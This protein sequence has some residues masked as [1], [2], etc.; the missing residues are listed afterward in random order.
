MK[1][2]KAFALS[3]VAA[4]LSV[5]SISG[6]AQEDGYLKPAID[7]A[8]KINESAATSQQKVNSYAEQIDS[9]LVEFR[10]IVKETDGYKVYNDQMRQQ[11]SAQEQEMADLNASI[12]KVSV[13]ERQIT[14]LMLRMI[15]GL[16]Q[17]IELDVPFLPEERSKRIADL[18]SMM[19]RADVTS[20][21]KFRRIMEAY[22]VEMN[23]GKGIE[24]YEGS[25]DI[26]GQEQIVDFLRVGR[27]ILIYQTRDG[28][29][30]GAW[31][32]NTG[33]W[34]ELPSSY[35]SQV[36]KGLR[37]AKKQMAPNLMVLPVSLSE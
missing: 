8:K 20:S 28:L 30:Q 24:A 4:A 23:F 15:D 32:K 9:K 19:G 11:I 12:D 27:T 22:E 18:H 29:R 2:S 1:F 17:F 14:P 31:N 6:S 33:T 35:R 5:A 37:M 3:V 10:N 26:D 16:E 36:V 13:I 25:V 21:E 34:E 7:S